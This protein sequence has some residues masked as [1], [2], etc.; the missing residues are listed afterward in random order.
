MSEALKAARLELA[1][2]ELANRQAA[3]VPTEPY[4]DEQGVTRYPNLQQVESGAFED[5]VGAGLAGM[6][7]GVK[8]VIETPEML[9]RAAIRGG[10]EI[11]QLAGGEVKKEMPVFNTATGRGIKALTSTFGGD[12]AMAYRGESTPAQFAGTIG[13]FVGPAGLIGSGKKL[14]QASVAAGAGSEAAGQIAEGTKAE[15]Y[16]RAAGAIIGGFSPAALSGVKNKTVLA[17][18]KNAEKTMTADVL[19]KSKNAKYDYARSLGAEV[20][21]DMKG[22]NAYI[23]NEIKNAP[24]DLFAGYTRGVDTHIDNALKVLSSRSSSTLN[25]SQMEAV[26]TSLKNIYARGKGAGEYAYDPRVGF[27]INKLDEALDQAPAGISGG[28]AQDAF[29]LAR[30]ENRRFRKIEMFEDMMKKADLDAGQLGTSASL[31]DKQRNAMRSIIKSPSRKAQFEPKELEVMEAFVRGKIPEKVMRILGKFGPTTGNPFTAFM[32]LGAIYLNPPL[33][34]ASLGAAAARSGSV[35]SASNQF[36]KVKQE[37]ISGIPEKQ[38]KLITD[39]EIMI[40]LGL[41]AE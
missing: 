38:R 3:P 36:K 8:G 9:G 7:R 37:I 21:I 30:S 10:Q 27:I 35:I 23:K 2:R 31:V 40:L 13:E 25:Q 1:K 34:M 6:A 18:E 26:R 5:V 17:F 19:R 22:F 12:K 39:R 41:Q 28:K 4:V 16:A 20:N 29:K 14:M 11:Y 15:P 32:N 24:D 33:I